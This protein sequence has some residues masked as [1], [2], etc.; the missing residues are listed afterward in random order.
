MGQNPEKFLPALGRG[1]KTPKRGGARVGGWLRVQYPD[2]GICFPQVP[3]SA[4]YPITGIYFGQVLQSSTPYRVLIQLIFG[5]LVV[6]TSP[7]SRFPYGILL[8][9]ADT[10]CRWFGFEQV[11]QGLVFASGCKNTTTC[12]FLVLKFI[13]RPFT[14][15]RGRL[16]DPIPLG[17]AW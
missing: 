7:S 2:L 15:S 9:A 16:V 6:W 11:P 10:T 5:L 1:G 4:T 14:N 13:K 17:A 3:R 8:L 12:G